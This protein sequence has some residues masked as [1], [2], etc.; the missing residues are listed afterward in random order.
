MTTQKPSHCRQVFARCDRSYAC[1]EACLF[2]WRD[3]LQHWL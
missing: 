1:E 2:L 3:E